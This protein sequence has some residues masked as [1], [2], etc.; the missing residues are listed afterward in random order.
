MFA[1][2]LGQQTMLI[3]V[4][5]F[6]QKMPLGTE[7]GGHLGFV[8][9][10][11]EELQIGHNMQVRAEG[12]AIADGLDQAVVGDHGEHLL[13]PV[14]K[15]FYIQTGLVRV[16]VRPE[17]RYDLMGCHRTAIVQEQV[18]DQ[19][20]DLWGFHLSVGQNT[21]GCDNLKIV[22]EIDHNIRVLFDF[23]GCQSVLCPIHKSLFIYGGD[24]HESHHLQQAA[25]RDVPL[26]IS[27]NQETG[28]AFPEW[29]GNDG[30][31]PVLFEKGILKR[32]FISDILNIADDNWGSLGQR[33]NPTP[34]IITFLDIAEGVGCHTLSLSI[35]PEQRGPD[36]H[37]QVSFHDTCPVTII[38]FGGS[39]QHIHDDLLGIIRVMQPGLQLAQSLFYILCVLNV[40]IPHNSPPCCYAKSRRSACYPIVAIWQLCGKV[41]PAL[42]NRFD[43]V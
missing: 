34:Q 28:G 7:I 9:V 32:R 19:T 21:P 42:P 40:F 24:S 4:H 33:V 3:Y 17:I 25:V 29:N 23:N 26:R 22:K 41:F 43:G 20:G 12:I 15:T 11:L 10:I 36:F 1:G 30:F 37:G 16:F 2:I 38:E 5:C 13:E 18:Y 14:H 27:D 8:E 35:I 6:L 31:H 39:N